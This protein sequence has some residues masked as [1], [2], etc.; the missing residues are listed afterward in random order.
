MIHRG[1]G[2]SSVNLVVVLIPISAV[3]FVDDSVVMMI[4]VVVKKSVL[5]LISTC[6]DSVAS[7][8]GERFSLIGSAQRFY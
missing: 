7:N 8:L 3:A 1:H 6:L 2:E 5:K 4:A